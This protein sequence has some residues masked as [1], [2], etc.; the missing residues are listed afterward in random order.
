MPLFVSALLMSACQIWRMVPCVKRHVIPSTMLPCQTSCVLAQR[1]RCII[2]LPLDSQRYQLKRFFP[3]W[4]KKKRE[5][6]RM[7]CFDILCA[8]RKRYLTTSN[9]HRWS[10]KLY[11]GKKKKGRLY[12]RRLTS[13]LLRDAFCFCVNSQIVCAVDKAEAGLETTS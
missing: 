2:S 11:C 1:I 8:P 4:S 3:L 7:K 6:A 5:S 13:P 10:A 12:L 9:D